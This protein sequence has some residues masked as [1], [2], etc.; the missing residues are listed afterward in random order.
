LAIE[1]ASEKRIPYVGADAI[2]ETISAN[3]PAGARIEAGRQFLQSVDDHV[4]R[5][6]SLVVETTLSGRT[7]A[8]TIAESKQLGYNVSIAYL[9][10]ESADACVA[11]VTERVR[12]GGHHVPDEDVRRRFARSIVNFWTIYRKMADNWVLLYNGTGQLLDVAGG[13]SDDIS[14]RDTTLFKNF[15]KIVEMPSNE[16]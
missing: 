4:S 11:R 16:H 7:F 6:K 10:L 14:V 13:S 15:M 12:K 3:D 9:C 5:R 1:Y 2:A 8:N